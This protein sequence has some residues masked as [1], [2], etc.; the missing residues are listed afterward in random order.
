MAVFL[1]VRNNHQNIRRNRIFRDRL[2][3]LDA[4]NDDEIIRRYRLSR[5]L[6]INLYDQIGADLEPETLRNHAIPGMLQIFVALRFYACGSFQ[7]VVGDGIGIHKSSVSRIITRVTQRL[8]RLRNRFIKFP[9]NINDIMSSKQDF[10]EIAEFPNVIGAI[11]GTLISIKTPKEDEHRYVSRKGGH[12]LN[13]LATCDSNLMFTYVV[14]KYPGSTNDSFIWTNCNLAQKFEQGEFG[15]S[16]LLGDS[17]CVSSI[18]T[19]ITLN[20]VFYFTAICT[21]KM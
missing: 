20:H 16:W 1:H 7:A 8:V 21:T 14:S 18:F 2:H 13:V 9:R 19:I 17:G 11:D 4:Y 12:S 6:I 10:H 3:P 15:N 5:E